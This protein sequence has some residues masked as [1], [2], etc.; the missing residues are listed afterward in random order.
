MN[1]SAQNIEDLFKLV[2][3]ICEEIGSNK[4]IN[5]YTWLLY[6]NRGVSA[7][8]KTVDE[9]HFLL[10]SMNRLN[11]YISSK[12]LSKSSSLD[13]KFRTVSCMADDDTHITILPNGNIGKC[14]HHLDDEYIGSIYKNDFDKSKIAEWKVQRKSIPLCRTCPLFMECRILDKCP[15][16]ISKQ[17]DVFEQKLRFCTLEKQMIHTYKKFKLEKGND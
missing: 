10:D 4:R 7:K 15:D 2:D 14:D 17:C 13:D 8:T 3:V 12:G 6:D 1:V 11:E 5:V 16:A 9:R